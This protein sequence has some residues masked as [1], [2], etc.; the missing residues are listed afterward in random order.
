M[1]FW[2]Y[3]VADEHVMMNNIAQHSLVPK[4]PHSHVPQ[5]PHPTLQ[6]K[7]PLHPQCN[8][9]KYNSIMVKKIG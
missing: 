3:V 2:G 7:R 5:T 6:C 4:T 8:I 9:F 1:W